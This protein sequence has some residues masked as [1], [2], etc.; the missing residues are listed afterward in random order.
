[1]KQ[2]FAWYRIETGVADPL[3][4]DADPNPRLSDANLRPL[5]YN[6]PRLLF[7]PPRH[8][9]EPPRPSRPNCETLQILNFDFVADPKPAFDVDAYPD[10][11][12]HSKADP[13]PASQ[14]YVNPDPQIRST[15]RN[16]PLPEIILSCFEACIFR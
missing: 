5:F 3:Q 1:L 11:G 15:D 8:H 10:P 7:E 14:I 12:F 2:A 6:P 9:C 13:D 4:S 16:K